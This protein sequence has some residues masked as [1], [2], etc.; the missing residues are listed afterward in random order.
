MCDS[1]LEDGGYINGKVFVFWQNIVWLASNIQDFY[2]IYKIFYQ[3]SSVYGYFQECK[4][5]SVPLQAWGGPEGFRKL[6]YLDSMTT[7]QDGGKVVSPTHRPPLL[8]G[9]NPGTHF[10]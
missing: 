5:K 3:I 10:C 7:A 4:G 6:R 8:P 1:V 9:N 2:Q